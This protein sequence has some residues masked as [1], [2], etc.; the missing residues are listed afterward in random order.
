MVHV[1]EI[2]VVFIHYPSSFFGHFQLHFALS[3]PVWA[4]SGSHALVEAATL[5]FNTFFCCCRL[6]SHDRPVLCCLR[7]Y[8]FN[9]GDI[10]GAKCVKIQ[11][12]GC[13]RRIVRAF[14]N[15]TKNTMWKIIFIHFPTKQHLQQCIFKNHKLPTCHHL[16]AKNSWLS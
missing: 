5:E 14:I 13:N 2:P 6:G 11:K 7:D 3:S 12:K 10:I 9:L 16:N 4:F 1:S 15:A 8:P